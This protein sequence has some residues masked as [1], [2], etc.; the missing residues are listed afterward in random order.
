MA[1]HP[2]TCTPIGILHSPLKTRSEAP[3][4]GRNTGI[5]CTAEIFPEY[6]PALEGIEVNS[7]LIL[8]CWFDRAERNIL[9]ISPPHRDSA[10]SSKMH[11]VFARRS[12]ARPN[13]IAFE[14]G[15]LLNVDGTVLTL[16]GL[17]VLEGTPILDIKPYSPKLDCV[18]E[19]KDTF[20]DK[21]RENAE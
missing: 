11:G 17:D 20:W 1:L 19:A 13:P 7:H 21:K 4:Q 3:H 10:H 16:R 8:L 2:V 5:I 18:P 6:A 9:Q 12:P 14:I 15:E